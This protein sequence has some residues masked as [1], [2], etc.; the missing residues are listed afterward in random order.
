MG[1]ETLP[2]ITLDMTTEEIMEDDPL[3]F[4][5]YERSMIKKYMERYANQKDN[6]IKNM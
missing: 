6:Q 3:T 4:T 2:T 5:D 1:N